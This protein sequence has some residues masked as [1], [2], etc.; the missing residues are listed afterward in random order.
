MKV[1]TVSIDLLHQT[2]VKLKTQNGPT[3]LPSPGLVRLKSWI[4]VKPNPMTQLVLLYGK[5]NQ[6]TALLK[7][8]KLSE[9]SGKQR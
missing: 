7:S 5:K 4:A 9:Y 6:R 2:T 1:T 3:P 8:I